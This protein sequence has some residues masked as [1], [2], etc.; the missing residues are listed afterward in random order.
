MSMSHVLYCFREL[1]SFLLLS[2]E[3]HRV[4]R[5]FRREVLGDS[6]GHAIALYIPKDA[7]V[8]L[9]QQMMDIACQAVQSRSNYRPSACS[10]QA[11]PSVCLCVQMPVYVY[12]ILPGS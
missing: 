1:R 9:A 2:V 4:T 5:E 6:R 12:C 10:H 7:M 3:Q 11:L 8:K